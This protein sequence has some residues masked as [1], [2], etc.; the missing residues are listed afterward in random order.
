[1]ALDQAKPAKEFENALRR[2]GWLSAYSRQVLMARHLLRSFAAI[3]HPDDI[4]SSV[5]GDF[6]LDLFRCSI[7]ILAG[8]NRDTQQFSSPYDTIN[9]PETHHLAYKRKERIFS[10]S[11]A[12]GMPDIHFHFGKGSGFGFE[13]SNEI[14]VEDGLL[15]FE[16]HAVAKNVSLTTKVLADRR[17]VAL[18]NEKLW[19][20]L[21]SEDQADALRFFDNWYEW[22]GKNGAF[23]REWYQGFLDGKPLDWELQR[24]VALIDDAIWKAG[25]E[26]V[27]EEIE[28]IRAKF[29]LEKRIENLEAELRRA[30]VNRHGIGGNKPPEMLDKSPIAQELIIVWQPL[31]DLKEEISKEDPDPK[32]LQTIIKT[33]VTVMKK[34]FAWCLKK[35]NLIVDTAIKWAIPASGTGYLA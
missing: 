29:D 20:D 25:P 33:L 9:R 2:L 28:K 3:S 35:G 34:G 10:A 17:A 15:S 24:R 4:L 32:H 14:S 21:I 7:T 8:V 6:A 31:E 11:I 12:S 23:W 5:P 19:R 30:T 1:M 18:R 22:A 26:A 13:N 16:I 27:A